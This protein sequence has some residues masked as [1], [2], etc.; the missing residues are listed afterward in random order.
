MEHKQVLALTIISFLLCN[1]VAYF[2]EGLNSFNYLTHGGDW[3]A[4]FMYTVLFLVLPLI[5][6]FSFKK[7]KLRLPIALIGFAPVVLLLTIQL[8]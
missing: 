2:D 3:V 4:L 5:L 8:A 6:F 7:S 1:A